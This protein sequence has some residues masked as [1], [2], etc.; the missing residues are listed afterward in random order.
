MG[1]ATTHISGY[2]SIQQIRFSKKRIAVEVQFGHASFLGT[3]L[4]KFQMASYSNLDLIDFGVYITTAKAMQ[5]FL[6]NQYGHNWEGSLNF[7]KVEKYLP[8]FKSAIQVP[9]Y[10]IGIDV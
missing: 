10:V 8:Y 3:D 1:G 9:I 2:E 6:T 5:K 7:E 4:L